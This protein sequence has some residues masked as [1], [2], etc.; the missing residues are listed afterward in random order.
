[1]FRIQILYA[2]R[3]DLEVGNIIVFLG[4]MLQSNLYWLFHIENVPEKL[5]KICYIFKI[6]YLI[7]YVS[8]YAKKSIK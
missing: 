5:K 6:I 2:M 3:I 7:K 1:M 8:M 4:V